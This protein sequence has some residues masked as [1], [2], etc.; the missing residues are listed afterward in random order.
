MAEGYGL[1]AGA[2]KALLPAFLP[3]LSTKLPAHCNAPVADSSATFGKGTGNEKDETSRGTSEEPMFPLVLFSHG[4]GGTRTLYSSMC[5]EMASYGFVVCVVEHRDGSGPRTFVN[6]SDAINGVASR[7][8]KGDGHQGT[9][10][11]GK[12]RNFDIVDFIWPAENPSDTSPNND[13]GVE[14]SLRDAQLA[15]RLMEL[16]EAYGVICQI[17]KGDGHQVGKR[18]LRKKDSRGSS[19]DSVDWTRWRNRIHLDQVTVCG[20]SFGAAAIIEV[21]RRH[22]RFPYASQGIIYDVWGDGVAPLDEERKAEP[23]S[24]PVLAIS[25]EAFTHWRHN[26]DA[27]ERLMQETQSEPCPSPAWLLTV[28]GTVH[29]SSTD[30]PLL[31]PHITSLFLKSTANPRRALD[32]H[33]SAT[34]EFLS[35]VLRKDVSMNVHMPTHERLLDAEIRR[36]DDI[37]QSELR[38]PDNDEVGIR[39]KVH[40]DWLYRISPRLFRQI[41]RRRHQNAEESGEHW[42]HVKPSTKVMENYYHTLRV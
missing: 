8:E 20:H 2:G 15:M 23:I 5:G 36:L 17:A 39:L 10:S 27:V 19:L 25:S 13:Q 18:D 21:L 6:Y 34:L 30:F 7:A 24:K 9:S 3:I 14:R 33:I 1:F 35:K 16:E 38:R 11:S 22:E 40:H 41:E 29:V 12:L 4:L 31:Y 37:P 28:R 32:L 42:L 26:Y